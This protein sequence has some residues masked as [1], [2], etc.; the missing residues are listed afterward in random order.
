MNE[1]PAITADEGPIPSFMHELL[2]AN[3]GPSSHVVRACCVAETLCLAARRV[4][5]LITKLPLK[6]E[7]SGGPLAPWSTNRGA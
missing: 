5:R 1:F 7:L 2:N 4:S 6:Q 3:P